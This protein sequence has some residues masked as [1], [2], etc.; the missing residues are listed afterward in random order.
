MRGFDYYTGI[1]FEC[2]AKAGLRRALFGGGRYDNLT[3]TVGGR[4][5]LPGLGFAVGDVPVLEL[6]RDRQI[7]PSFG[8]PSNVFVTIFS[9]DLAADSMKLATE[10]R[11]AG[12][13]TT[14]YNAPGEK[15]SKQLQFADGEKMRY[16]LIVGP[17]EIRSKTVVVK[18]L[19]KRERKSVAADKIVGFFSA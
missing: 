5:A 8:S 17:D 13:P 16:A 6:L 10:L 1:V 19:E 14:V 11:R 4:R 2:W 3:R 18:D 9:D 12:V 7:L 15:L